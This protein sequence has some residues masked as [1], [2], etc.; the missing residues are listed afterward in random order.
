MPAL[1]TRP[2][3]ETVQ[4][5]NAGLADYARDDEIAG[6]IRFGAAQGA[7]KEARL[8]IGRI[9]FSVVWRN[10]WAAATAPEY[11][12]PIADGE[13]IRAFVQGQE[14]DFDRLLDAAASHFY[15]PVIHR[16]TELLTPQELERVIEDDEHSI[17]G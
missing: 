6:A 10:L 9:W 8:A 16:R 13:T 5:W 11:L 15:S 14:V 2:D 12:D 7:A 3:K 17:F 4:G 1:L